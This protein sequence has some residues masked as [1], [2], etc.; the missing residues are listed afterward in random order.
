MTAKNAWPLVIAS[1]FH[2][3]TERRSGTEFPWPSTREKAEE[4]HIHH[5]APG[6]P[7]AAIVPRMRN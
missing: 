1:S 4:T 2:T 6:S 7:H 5:F 3:E